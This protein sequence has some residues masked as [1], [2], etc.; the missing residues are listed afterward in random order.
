MMDNE[1]KRRLACAYLVEV[2]LHRAC[3]AVA[4]V[5]L[6]RACAAVVVMGK[7]LQLWS[8][9]ECEIEDYLWALRCHIDCAR[10]YLAQALPPPTRRG[11]G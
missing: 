11:R 7:E 10:D 6:H 2:E 8:A 4:E 5:E 1:T 3:V 9:D